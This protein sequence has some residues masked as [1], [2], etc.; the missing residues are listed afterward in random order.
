MP[1]IL[2]AE[3]DEPTRNF[4]VMKLREAGH[5]VD[6]ARNGQELIILLSCRR[7]DVIISDLDMTGKNGL[8]VLREIRRHPEYMSLPFVLF[9]RTNPRAKTDNVNYDSLMHELEALGAVFL[10]KTPENF[11]QFPMIRIDK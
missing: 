2:L 4:M 10:P 8:E 11:R 3:P 6:A 7:H 9:S 5:E 1:C